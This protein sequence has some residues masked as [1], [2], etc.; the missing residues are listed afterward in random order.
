MPMP[1][2]QKFAVVL[3]SG[4]IVEITV[5]GED[6]KHGEGLAIA[7]AKEKYGEQIWDIA[8]M[9]VRDDNLKTN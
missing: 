7:E 5:F 9:P 4:K 3:E 8:N 1:Y 6:S 2:K